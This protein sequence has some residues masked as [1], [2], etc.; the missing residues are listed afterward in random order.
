LLAARAAQLVVLRLA[1]VV[2][3]APFGSEP[4]L[5][6]ETMQGGVERPFLD[7]QIGVR[8]RLDPFGDRVS[9]SRSPR[10]GL[11]NEHVERAAEQPT[12]RVHDV[13]LPSSSE[14]S[15][16]RWATHARAT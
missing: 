14:G 1:I 16:P 5:S 10:H 13:L 8:D 11:E 2:G 6:L 3:V 7:Q 15:S 12:F 4:A 9:V